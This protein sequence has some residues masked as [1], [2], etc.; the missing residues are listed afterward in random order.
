MAMTLDHARTCGQP[1]RVVRR[2]SAILMVRPSVIV[3]AMRVPSIPL[4]DNRITRAVHR[5]WTG[6]FS[7]K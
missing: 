1:T 6:T 3:D 7:L 4:V 5:Y 2:L